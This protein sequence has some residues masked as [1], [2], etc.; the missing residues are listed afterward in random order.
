MIHEIAHELTPDE[1]NTLLF[2]TGGMK[3]IKSSEI[4]KEDLWNLKE[5]FGYNRKPKKLLK[6]IIFRDKV[7]T[8]VDD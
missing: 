2:L 7:I 3:I 6:T 1:R 4:S 8:K 5:F